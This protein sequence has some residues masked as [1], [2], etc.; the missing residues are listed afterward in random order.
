MYH[1]LWHYKDLVTKPRAG[2]YGYKP[3]GTWELARDK[4]TN[5]AYVN[6]DSYAYDA[7]AIYVQQH[8][9]SSM[10]PVP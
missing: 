2:D 10:S 9:K 4:G 7:V 6:A 1:E 5:Y 3:Q 8:F